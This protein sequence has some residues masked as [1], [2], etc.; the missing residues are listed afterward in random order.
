[1]SDRPTDQEHAATVARAARDGRDVARAAASW[2]AP[3]SPE[4]AL[5]ILRMARDG[6]DRHGKTA[7]LDERYRPPDLSGEY[8]DDPTGRDMLA[9]A[10][11]DRYA[12]SDEAEADLAEQEIADAWDDAVYNAFYGAIET[13]AH[14]Y[15][16]AWLNA[17]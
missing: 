3:D 10:G 13:Q 12:Y 17:S 16:T 7:T 14:Y 1:M 9:G 4:D 6:L 15:L 2:L 5:E 8:A 11:F